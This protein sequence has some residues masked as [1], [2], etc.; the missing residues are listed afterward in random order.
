MNLLRI[1]FQDGACECIDGT[2]GNSLTDRGTTNFSVALEVI[3]FILFI[4]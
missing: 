1:E 2:L 4:V 3:L